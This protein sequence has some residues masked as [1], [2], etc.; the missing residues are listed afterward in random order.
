MLACG[1][2]QSSAMQNRMF[3]LSAALAVPDPLTATSTITP[4]STAHHVPRAMRSLLSGSGKIRPGS[5]PCMGAYLPCL[6][7]K[8]LLGQWRSAPDLSR[9][10]GCPTPL[11]MGGAPLRKWRNPPAISSFLSRSFFRRT[12]IIQAA[13]APSNVAQRPPPPA[14]IPRPCCPL[15]SARL[16]RKRG[17]YSLRR[18]VCSAVGLRQ[19]GGNEPAPRQCLGPNAPQRAS[20]AS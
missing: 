17:Y 7:E 19:F 20:V 5:H 18:T 8:A 13:N 14:N 6:W 15:H 10:H 2:D 11:L 16:E 9:S 4:A 1:Y 12:V 3:G